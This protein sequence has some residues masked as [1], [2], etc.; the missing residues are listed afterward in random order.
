MKKITFILLL[1][2]LPISCFKQDAPDVQ[3]DRERTVRDR[4]QLKACSDITFYEGFLEHKNVT[5]L[6]VCTSWDRKF[7]EMFKALQ[8]IPENHWNTILMPIDE[9][10]FAD[11]ARRD[12]FIS[13]YRDLDND[14]ALDDLGRVITALTDTNF[15][16]GLNHLFLCAEEPGNDICSGREAAPN[17]DEIKNFFNILNRNPKLLL[18]LSLVI[19]NFNKAIAGDSE[20]LRTEINKFN[21]TDFFNSLRVL[22]VSEFARKYIDGLEEGDLKL[23]N[24]FFLTQVDGGKTWAKSWVDHPEV[25]SE[26]LL[27]TF[28]LPV[29]EEKQFV[30]DLKVLTELY[31]NDVRCDSDNNLKLDI[32]S[33][34]QETMKHLENSEKEKFFDKLVMAAEATKLAKPFCS[35]VINAK[36]VVNYWE[37]DQRR[38][39]NHTLDLTNAL[40]YSTKLL[41]G[42]Q[43]L[44]FVRYILEIVD[45]DYDYL[46]TL[47]SSELFNV[48]NEVN[49]VVYENAS[50]FYEVVLRILKRADDQMFKSMAVL[51]NEVINET[52]S[53]DIYAWSKVWLFWK[54]DEQNFLFNFIDRHLDLD[55]NYIRLFEFY[56]L[57]FKETSSSWDVLRDGYIRNEEQKE[58]TYQ[59][60][61]EFSRIFHGEQILSDYKRFFSRDHILDLL[62]VITSGQS[63]TNNQIAQLNVQYESDF[64]NLP[65]RSFTLVVGGA[66]NSKSYDCVKA[67]NESQSLGD[68]LTNYPEQ[69]ESLSSNYAIRDIAT[70]MNTIIEKYTSEYPDVNIDHFFEI[71]GILSPDISLW[72]L[73]TGVELNNV[74]KEDGESLDDLFSFF[75]K[76]L[77]K[78]GAEGEKGVNLISTSIGFLKKWVQGEEAQDFR[79]TMFRKLALNRDSVEKLN[80]KLPVYIN[81]YEEWKNNYVE[82]KYSEDSNYSCDNFL[83]TNVGKMICPKSE[84]VKENIR[85]LVKQMTTQYEES[86]GVAVD[87]IIDAAT[88]GGGVKIPLDARD[89]KLKRLTLIES[90]NYLYDLSDKSLAVNNTLVKHR[91]Y[92]GD[93]KKKYKLTTSERID[94][95]IRNVA[96]GHNYLGVQY[97]NSIVKGHDYTDIVKEKKK[98]MGLCVNAPVVRCGKKMS[99]EERRMARN[100]LWAYDGLIDVNNGNDVEPKLKYGKYMQTFLLSLVGSSAKESQE[101]TFWPLKEDLLKKHNGRALGYFSGMASFSN[102]GRTVHDRVGRTKAEFDEFMA[103][104]E[105]KRVNDFL[106]ANTDRPKLKKAIQDLLKILHDSSGDND[107]VGNSVD[108]INTISYEEL[109]LAEE[110]ISKTLYVST[111]LGSEKFVYGNGDESEFS[112]HSVYELL[113]IS[114]DLLKEHVR[115]KAQFPDKYFLKDSISPALTIMSFF[116]DMLSN[117]ERS[118]EYWYLLNLSYSALKSSLHD[119]GGVHF[120]VDNLIKKNEFSGLVDL[121]VK[122]KS[123][124][125]LVHL[126]GFDEISRTIDKMNK[127][128]VDSDAMWNYVQKSTIARVCS[129]ESD[130]CTENP[131]YDELYKFFSLLDKEDNLLSLVD[132]LLVEKRDNLIRTSEE[133]FPY[134]RVK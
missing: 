98:L 127:V 117:D 97:L 2:V 71:G 13:Y 76:Y 53:D 44:E 59:A 133:F 55:T 51:S 124:L 6:F 129:V 10:F 52:Q 4:D 27:T 65:T 82:S 128:D 115:I 105:F 102:M 3:S 96:F 74:Y 131:T 101:V 85:S 40:T 123:Y 5:N 75:N 15:Y 100:A 34:V 77:K 67:I 78:I 16:D 42:N 88:Y 110:L 26:Y 113:A 89:A 121:L 122:S 43:S 134:I 8:Q 38:N 72:A 126:T 62:S 120:L 24:R 23:V 106:F 19:D 35:D 108:W 111:F 46:M 104:K 86:E 12:R 11:H 30:R 83:N 109:R 63:Y 21:N 36:R 70:G 116:Y 18:E 61:K 41:S 49:R 132:W 50:P 119:T 130:D 69:C 91:R 22:L 57:F 93:D 20:N 90:F 33:L 107:L 54:K 47:V 17:K 25:N 66:S 68:L 37:Y 92:L 114:V 39:V 99:K 58:I 48:G 112:E 81:E 64:N 9:I 103:K 79:N 80:N 125:D 31:R 87:Y 1:S 28:S 73:A 14:G 94:L 84:E 95:V 7:V 118:R 60:F 45:S 29:L 32:K 56:S